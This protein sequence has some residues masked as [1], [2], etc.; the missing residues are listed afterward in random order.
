MSLIPEGHRLI[1]VGC[2]HAQLPIAYVL[3]DPARRAVAIDNKPQPLAVAKQ[4][5]QRA[6]VTD[7]L[8]IMLH[9]GV[10]SGLLQAGDTVV[11]AGLGGEETKQIISRLDMMPDRLLLAPHSRVATLRR[12]LS[13]QRLK[14]V[15]EHVL[16]DANRPYIV[17]SVE[18]H[19]TPIR[20]SQEAIWIGPCLLE[21]R[22]EENSEALRLYLL[23]LRRHL[24]GLVKGMPELNTVI[25]KV[26]R[27]LGEKH[28]DIR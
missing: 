20:L 4:N 7:R 16:V 21:R 3:G 9:D 14:I 13:E 1:D 22:G 11:V 28:D 24:N 27:L 23:R 8:Q 10:P 18:P 26:N 15:A 19:P 17:L 5:A 2:D 6:G 12:Y 25:T